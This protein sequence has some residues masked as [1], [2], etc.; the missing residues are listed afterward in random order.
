MIS[1]YPDHAR[2]IIGFRY[3]T[4]LVLARG[5]E[6]VKARSGADADYIVARRYAVSVQFDG[7]D[8]WPIVVPA[9]FV[10]DLSSVPRMARAVVDRVG[11][12][13]EASVVHDFLY[14]AWQ[15]VAGRGAREADR[16]F[17]DLVLLA[18]MWEAR[19]GSIQRWMIY[20][21]V[22]AFGSAAYRS[23]DPARWAVVPKLQ[24]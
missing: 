24:P 19:V 8:W 13:L 4:P 12:Q 9:G 21:A 3:A 7:G 11:P 23:R 22:R 17:A 5:I 2:P 15:D 10:T 16:E 6:A 14:V 18:G 20:R 1:P